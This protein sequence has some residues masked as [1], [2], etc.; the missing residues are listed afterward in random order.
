[1]LIR[2]RLAVVHRLVLIVAISVT[3]V[4]AHTIVVVVIFAVDLR[5][6]I[7]CRI[8]LSGCWFNWLR[9]LFWNRYL[10]SRLC[11]CWR[12]YWLRWLSCGD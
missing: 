9:Y 5:F 11:D 4:M 8:E 6:H 7:C 1:M 12:R 2:I 3:A 10:S